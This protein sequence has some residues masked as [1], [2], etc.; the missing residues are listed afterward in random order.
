MSTVISTT[1]YKNFQVVVSEIAANQYAYKIDNPFNANTVKNRHGYTTSSD[2]LAAGEA[3]IDAMA[4]NQS[5]P[6]IAAVLSG[7]NTLANAVITALLTAGYNI[8]LDVHVTG[9]DDNGF[10]FGQRC[11]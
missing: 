6:V 3:Y 9:G 7:N 2:A 5:E 11:D 10:T 1:T 8:G 4:V